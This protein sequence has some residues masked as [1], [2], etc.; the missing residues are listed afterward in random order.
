MA[1]GEES[2]SDVNS[3]DEL[4]E[5]ENLEYATDC[6]MES[7][8]SPEQANEDNN[9]AF[10]VL[11]TEQT[12][13]HMVNSI[14]EV[15]T[16]VGIPVTT[17]RILLNH[18]KWDKEK[19][20][21]RFYDGNQE[22]LFENARVI[23][24]FKHGPTGDQ[25][26][27]CSSKRC[28]SKTEKEQCEICFSTLTKHMMTG[29]ECGHRFCIDCW[30]EYLT[31]KIMEEGVGQTISCAAH[32][33]SILV[34]DASVMQLLKHRKVKLKYQLLITNS[35]VECNRLLT[36][37]PAP[38]CSNAIKVQYPGFQSVTCRCGHTFCFSCGLNWHDPVKCDLLR[39]WIKKCVD[40]SETY[41]W[42]S[43]NTKDCPK[44]KAV[45]EKNG[46]CNRMLCTNGSCRQD[47]CWVCLK[48]WNTHTGNAYNCNRYD[49]D[50]QELKEKSRIFLE[51][52]LFYYS[53]YMNHMQS[54]KFEH[55][56]YA[57]VRQKMDEMQEHSM[58]WIEVQF[59]NKAVDIL[60][61]CRQTLMY[62][63]VFPYYLKKN[64]QTVIF[65]NNQQDLERATECLSEY[66][67]RDITSEN[68]I[69]IKQ[70]VQDKYKYCAS[71]REALLNHVHEGYEENWWD[72]L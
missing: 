40:D 55:K 19:L 36:W 28:T 38:D 24:P 5:D 67:E 27:Q 6:D 7:G 26:S 30:D 25:P 68:H 50:N 17:A 56:L 1:A 23:N 61:L 43:A 48:F 15:N 65:E 53:R 3:G 45:I 58:A 21:E 20:M 64:N 57:S 31:T 29:L 35:F 51:R 39:N 16:V 49:G 63:Y 71:R 69:D 37:C 62:T 34:D 11:S 60:C 9:Q 4:N 46:G 72:H 54:L 44:C 32:D 33:C 2:C 8:D 22:K 10:E 18:F 70:K 47:F 41:N 52:Y 12:V 59:L 66:L 13:Q 42:I 14:R